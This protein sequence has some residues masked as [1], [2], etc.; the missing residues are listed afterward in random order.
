MIDQSLDRGLHFLARGRDDSR[1]FGAEGPIGSNFFHRLPNDLDALANLG[2]PHLISR[3][4]IACRLRLHVEIKLVVA[5]VRESLADVVGH[6][7]AAKQRTGRADGNGVLRAQAA[8]ALGSCHP[9]AVLREQVFVF[10][11]MAG[12]GVHHAPHAIEPVRRRLERESADAEIAGHHPL[13]GNVFVNLH[14]FFAL[15]EAVQ[16]NSHR[17]EVN[18]M[19]A[20]PNQVRGDAR[21]FRE[22]H[23]D[24]LRALGDFD[25]DKLFGGEA[26]TEIVRERREVVNPVGER[27][28]L[29]IG[30]GFARL[31]DAGMQVADLG[32]GREDDFSVELQHHAQNAMRGRVLRTHIEDHRLGRPGW[33]LDECRLC[34]HR[35]ALARRV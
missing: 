34:R 7:A 1:R 21:Q 29:R 19:R 11:D 8:D 24:V 20:E 28:A 18:G 25:P 2:D 5:G 10:V 35:S 26:E 14:D 3:E 9:D 33:R 30:F 13:A 27:D 31:F 23:A 17:A 22:K 16:E 15:A 6:A 12:Q 4:A 32:P